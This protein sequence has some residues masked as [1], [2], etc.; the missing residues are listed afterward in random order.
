MIKTF[1]YKD[2]EIDVKTNWLKQGQLYFG[3]KDI[4]GILQSV[5]KAAGFSRSGDTTDVLFL[6]D[7]YGR[8][9][10]ENIKADEIRYFGLKY[11]G[12]KMTDMSAQKTL[13]E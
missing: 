2:T 1:K 10:K 6:I 4:A 13:E 5:V 7:V 9:I 8:L 11:T 12:T 3:E